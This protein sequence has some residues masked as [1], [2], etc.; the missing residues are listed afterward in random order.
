MSGKVVGLPCQFP[1][2]NN[3][4]TF[5]SCTTDLAEDGISWCSTEVDDEGFH[6]FGT[7]GNCDCKSSD[8]GDDDSNVV[9]NPIDGRFLPNLNQCAAD[10]NTFVVRG[11]NAKVFEYP[12]AALVGFKRVRSEGS[13]RNK[14]MYICG[15]TL[16]NR[17]YV[18]TAAHCFNLR[19]LRPTE[20]LL[21]ELIVGQE[22]DCDTGGGRTR[23]MPPAQK[24]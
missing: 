8:D 16:I 14:V 4:R 18:L 10:A 15:G 17:R 1:F 7:W 11:R 9:D 20:V 6:V 24:V 19:S 22:P 2:K 21:R 3:K 13:G 5:D 23:C 12:F